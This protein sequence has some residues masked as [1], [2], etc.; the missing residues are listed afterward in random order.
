MRKL[1]K[2]I[3]AFSLAVCM[4]M[5]YTPDTYAYAAKNKNVT[6][7]T[8]AELKQ[9]LKNGVRNLV[10]SSKRGGTIT[11]PAGDYETVRLTI[12]AKKMTINNK[13]NF[14]SVVIK[15]AKKFLES[16]KGN[17]L[18]INDK[19]LKLI[20]TKKA[21]DT[22]VKCNAKNAKIDVTVN[23]K[24]GSIVLAKSAILNLNGDADVTVAQG[25]ENA[26][27]TI[28]NKD[29]KVTVHNKTAEN[30]KVTDT[31]GNVIQVDKGASVALGESEDKTD[32]KPDTGDDD[33]KDDTKPST[34]GG[35]GAGGGSSSSG[36]STPGTPANVAVT[37]ISAA[38]N[39]VTVNVGQEKTLSYTIAPSNATN[40][41]VTWTSSATATVT[42]DNGKITGK[43]AGT[44]TITAATEDGGF[45]CAW[46]VTVVP[47]PNDII[48]SGTPKTTIYAGDIFTLT[49]S[50]EPAGA[51]Q[52]VGWS[53]SDS[54]VAAISDT[55]VV[56]AVTAGD[57]TF[58]ATSTV[59]GSVT[60]TT[61]KVTIAAKPE[62]A[63]TVTFKVG[64][65]IYQ[66]VTF[67]GD[68]TT[69]GEVKPADPSKTGYQF[70]GWNVKGT[71]AKGLDD[72]TAINS[73]VTYQAIFTINT[74]TVTYDTGDGSAIGSASDIAYNTA[75]QLTDTKPTKPGYTF[76]GWATTSGATA[77]EYDA[78]AAYTVTAD[79]TFYAVWRINTYTITLKDSAS[80][81]GKITY[82]NKEVNASSGTISA[83]YNASE[84]VEINFTI[85]DGYYLA[86]LNVKVGE[87]AAVDA[88]KSVEYGYTFDDSKRTGSISVPKTADVMVTPEVRAVSAPKITVK[89][90]SVTW[91]EGDTAASVAVTDATSAAEKGTVT[92]RWY[93]ASSASTEGTAVTD[94]PGES[95]KI[96]TEKLDVENNGFVETSYYYCVATNTKNGSKA[97]T[98]SD[99]ITVT[100]QITPVTSL[101]GL[102]A[103]K[104]YVLVSD[105][106]V[107]T[108][109]T[110]AK[111][112]TLY[113]PAGVKLSI[114]NGATL[115][116]NGTVITTTQSV[117][118]QAS[119]ASLRS[120]R[121][122]NTQQ[123]SAGT[124][125]IASGDGDPGYC[126][127]NGYLVGSGTTDLQFSSFADL[128]SKAQQGLI[129][130]P[131][132]KVSVDGT[133][134]I[135][136][137]GALTISDAGRVGW[138]IN[139]DGRLCLGI[140][141][142]TTATV[143]DNSMDIGLVIV[144]GSDNEKATFD[145][146]SWDYFSENMMLTVEHDATF[147]VGDKVIAAPDNNSAAAPLFLNGTDKSADAGYGLLF[148]KQNGYITVDFCHSNLTGQT[149]TINGGNDGT[150][151]AEFIWVELPNR[152]NDNQ[153]TF[154]NDVDKISWGIMGEKSIVTKS[155]FWKNQ[156]GYEF[157]SL[158][159]DQT[160]EN[161]DDDFW[162]AITISVD[163]ML[164]NK[165]EQEDAL[166]SDENSYYIDP[167]NFNNPE[168][169]DCYKVV[170]VCFGEPLAVG[171]HKVSVKVAEGDSHTGFVW[172][173][174][175]KGN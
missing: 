115:T 82:T 114:L 108:D 132:M 3:L 26:Q 157:L 156:K 30:I 81:A 95:Y 70:V 4:L 89:N 35:G 167:L 44:A 101:D 16:A 111:D 174:I 98:K 163:G 86:A 47:D 67:T 168:K 63:K 27:I 131:G 104:R 142:G 97:Q 140:L 49:A 38:G 105:F 17:Q 119:G 113:I 72:S 11:I 118:P 165:L 148:Q 162:K 46:K 25:A 135:G 138:F 149:V 43:T 84:K 66:T 1:A 147:K 77:K 136:D 7:R 57:V 88:I 20:V 120:L 69:L 94:A 14:K 169:K 9:A 53:S 153:V 55:G 2:K 110:I 8:Q 22:A 50:V 18:T 6:V 161:F 121:L 150:I 146:G 32:N 80:N 152:V 139:G 71:E 125:E 160:I 78:G 116:E 143:R 40:K 92:Y 93:M 130:T 36:S 65:T 154:K 141:N 128:Q 48:I 134:Y 5:A 112:V 126:A 100:R 45:S 52:T 123:A 23:G 91:N 64:D 75:Y 59:K 31:D 124:I 13:G 109:T 19:S 83:E 137:G 74:Y 10:I 151:G 145:L 61:E 144:K 173:F 106:A 107:T 51:A 12:N 171:S 29:A 127:A 159:L 58:T 85:A 133:Q 34:G 37:G 33:K 79:V 73:D 117:E 28:V 42:V 21:E 60:K 122:R 155:L 90:I 24:V 15:D 87:A 96:S 170:Y 68:G 62:N 99:V 103:G 129:V 166:E 54:K 172:D 41:K 102:T 175:V 39:P 56:T 76:E 158:Y 164:L